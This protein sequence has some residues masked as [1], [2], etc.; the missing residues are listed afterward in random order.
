[1]SDNKKVVLSFIDWYRP[2]YKAGGTI[3]AFGNFVDHL[4]HAVEF[5]IITRD[6]DYTETN[7]Y[8]NISSDKWLELSNTWMYYISKTN[9]NYKVIKKL[10]ISTPYEWLYVNGI[11]SFYF[12]ILPIIVAQNKNSIVNPHGM[13][14]DQAFSVKNFKKRIF[15]QFA[16]AIS[17]YKNTVFHVAN[18]KEGNDVASRI[19]KFKDIQISNQ[20][21]RKMK[22]NG[23]HTD[24][25]KLSDPLRFVTVS[26]ISLE[27][28]I[29]EVLQ[30]LSSNAKPLI[31]DLYGA[32]YDV[33]YWNKCEAFITTLPSHIT[34]N[35]KGS[36]DGN[37][38]VDTLRTYDFFILLSKGENFGHAILEAFSAGCP[39]IISDQTPWKDLYS[40]K[41]GWDVDIND[42]NEIT[43]TL[44]RASEMS[45]TEYREWSK[46][47][48]EFYG[49]FSENPELLKNNLKLF[50]DAQ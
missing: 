15:V 25:K 48:M 47:A 2:G 32:I 7:P 40:K 37:L 44:N 33:E 3:T 20:M 41:I 29:Y 18:E 36:I 16:N 1:M 31:L 43:R 38:I 14:S 24:E 42:E 12:S 11:F 4:E 49:S 10:V 21:P 17:L 30:A 9:I 50:N 35:Y 39:V 46:N 22:L 13:L 19:K 26:R 5:K 23:I 27:K 28:G 45:Q 34:V 8:Q 6:T